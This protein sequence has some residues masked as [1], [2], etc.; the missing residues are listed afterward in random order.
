MKFRNALNEDHE[1]EYVVTGDFNL[2]HP[3]WG[4]DGSEQT[5]TPMSSE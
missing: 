5:L 4:G 2:H 1:A 3:E